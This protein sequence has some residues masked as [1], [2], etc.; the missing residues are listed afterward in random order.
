VIF[1][2]AGIIL[3]IQVWRSK[4]FERA[5]AFLSG[6]PTIVITALLAGGLWEGWRI[7]PKPQPPAKPPTAAE[8]AAEVKKIFPE[9]SL[10]ATTTIS[11]SIIRSPAPEISLIFKDSPLL[12]PERKRRIN[13][14]VNGFYLY[15]RGL[16]FPLEKEL[17]SF[18]VSNSNALSMSGVFPGTIYE[19]Q[20]YFPKNSLDDPDRIR[21]VYASYVFQILFHIF[22][23]RLSRDFGN[24]RTTATLFEVYY[25]SS[26]AGRNLD[27]S[28]WRGH[29]WMQALWEIRSQKGKDFTDRTM[30]YTYK[31]WDPSPVGEFDRK[32]CIRFLAGVWVIDNNGT[33]IGV[34][35]SILAKHHLTQKQ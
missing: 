34:V 4:P 24:D 29:K 26:F 33:S 23:D 27:K 15:L 9:G 12:T 16:G 19:R 8:I 3:S 32:F 10:G 18:G 30:Y 7:V 35:G 14:E 21:E 20:I 13:S 1:V 6:L 17:P 25:A 11:S 31:A 5:G 22:G 2:I 28:E